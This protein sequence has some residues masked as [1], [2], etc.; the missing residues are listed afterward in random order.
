M[1][2]FI[3]ILIIIINIAV[4]DSFGEGNDLMVDDEIT[5]I[6]TFLQTR[7]SNG[8]P[9]KATFSPALENLPKIRN[10]YQFPQRKR[11]K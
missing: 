8:V 4:V 6:S 1:I 9:P 2:N 3:I 10:F 7:F 5:P 11:P